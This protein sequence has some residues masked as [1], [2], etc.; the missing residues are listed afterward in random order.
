MAN[1]IPFVEPETRAR[2]SVS[3]KSIMISLGASLRR[4][5]MESGKNQ[6][7]PGSLRASKTHPPAAAAVSGS[8]ALLGFFTLPSGA[9]R[10]DRRVFS[11]WA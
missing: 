7:S 1:P 11:G 5:T 6:G 9:L 3:C 8:S 10:V 4:R 2:L